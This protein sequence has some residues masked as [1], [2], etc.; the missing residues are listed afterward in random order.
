MGFKLDPELADISKLSQDVRRRILMY[1]LK[2]G[3]SSTMLG[4]SPNYIN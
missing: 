2:K 1:V 4:F 3:V